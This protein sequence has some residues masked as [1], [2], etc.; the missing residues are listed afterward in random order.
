[1]SED[2]GDHIDRSQDDADT[3]VATS[4]DQTDPEVK[5]RET[6]AP[7]S[8]GT[9]STPAKEIPEGGSLFDIEEP[10]GRKPPPPAGS[11]TTTPADQ[12]AAA[13]STT[14]GAPTAAR[15][16]PTP[17]SHRPDD[18]EP[19]V[20]GA[21]EDEPAEARP[22]TRGEGRAAASRTTSTPASAIP[23]GGSLFDIEE[24]AEEKPRPPPPR[25][26]HPRRPGRRR[27]L[28][29]RLRH[30][31]QPGRRR[32]RDV[33]ADAAAAGPEADRRGRAERR[34]DD[35]RTSHRRSG[36]LAARHQGQ[37]LRRR[38]P[39]PRAEPA[40]GGPGPSP[41]PVRSGVGRLSPRPSG[42]GRGRRSRSRP[43]SSDAHQPRTDAEIGE[44]RSLFDL[45]GSTRLEAN[46]GG[47]PAPGAGCGPTPRIRAA[48]PDVTPVT[49]GNRPGPARFSPRG[50][51][52]EP[53]VATPRLS[54]TR[55]PSRPSPAYSPR[56]RPHRHPGAS[57]P[58]R[59][60]RSQ[61]HTAHP[62]AT[63]ASTWKPRPE[64]YPGTT[65]T[66]DLA[67]PM[68]DGVVLRGDLVRPTHA[69]GSS[70]RRRCR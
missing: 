24:P 58:P 67:I 3:D 43:A 60:L 32:P 2:Q 47:S 4:E 41:E 15:T 68:D 33:D 39:T 63:A 35:P 51:R 40:D 7:A 36:D 52:E 16:T 14:D 59:I 46:L 64:Q 22:R 21:T 19:E 49:S 1:M 70:D 62:A 12:D 13:D 48:P 34:G 66:K 50:F 38:G 44:G 6:P 37:V 65:T 56:Q 25:R 10:A 23:E 11:E 17:T 26:H 30:R 20:P 5:S 29:H 28:H 57:S 55:S 42:G 54:S 45:Y 9:T 69:D 27:R 31:P 61:R 53:H 8:S 18:A